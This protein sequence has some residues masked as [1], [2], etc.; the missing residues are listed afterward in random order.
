MPQA[1]RTPTPPFV[2]VGGD[3]SLDL[4]NTVDWTSA[5]LWHDRMRSYERFTTWAEG[6]GVLR[7]RDGER[8]RAAAR[9]HPRRAAAAFA[10]VEDVRRTLQALFTAAATG[11][12]TGPLLQRLNPLL[13]DALSHLELTS[14]GPHARFT[15]RG[16]GA[17]LASPLWPVVWAA[18]KLLDSAE[19]DRLR[20]CAG[21]DCGW[22]YVDRSRNGFRRWCEM[23]TCGTRAKSRRRAARRRR[24][25][26]IG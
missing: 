18:A 3:P 5:G 11:T 19:A 21:I 10:R 14:A 26:A 23:E 24:N 20:L 1:P 4:V 13:A 16:L 22:L 2:Y 17:D 7:R 15:W 9:V 8:L 6:A 12:A 25:A